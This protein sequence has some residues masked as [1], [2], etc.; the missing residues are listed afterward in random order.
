VSTGPGDQTA[1]G[2]TADGRFLASRTDRERVVSTLKAA[3]VEGR[4][5][6]DELDMRAGQAFAAR[7]YADL[8]ALTTDIPAGPAAARPGRPPASKRAV[9]LRLTACAIAMPVVI[10]FAAILSQNDGVTSALG[11]LLFVY[12]MASLMGVSHLVGKRLEQRHTRQSGRQLPPGPW[13]GEQ[14]L[15]DGQRGRAVHDPAPDGTDQTRADLRTDNSRGERP[16][17]LR[18]V[19]ARRGIRPVP[20]AV[21]GQ[22]Q[23]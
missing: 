3:F 18:E 9:M 19:R 10:V 22:P 20:G 14:V 5:T 4:L 16:S 13:P 11:P 23:A 17:P 1:A 12:L 21:L 7:T 2:E 6:K 15:K 8:A